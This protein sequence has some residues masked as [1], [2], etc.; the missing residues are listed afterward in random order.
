MEE[1]VIE[2]YLDNV[3]TLIYHWLWKTI[4]HFQIAV[5]LHTKWTLEECL[6]K[7]LEEIEKNVEHSWHVAVKT[8]VYRVPL[9]ILEGWKVSW[10]PTTYW[11]LTSKSLMIKQK[12][13]KILEMDKKFIFN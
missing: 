10:S 13:G 1:K 7:L 9:P 3:A 12:I 11:H 2:E 4:L 5:R 6:E 8:N